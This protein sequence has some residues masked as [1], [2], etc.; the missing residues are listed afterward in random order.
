[1]EA[2]DFSLRE[3]GDVPLVAAAIHDGHGVRAEVAAA[4]ALTE[5]KRLREEDPFTGGWTMI[6]STRIVG[7]RSRFEVDLNRPRERA[8]Y[9]RPEDAWGLHVWKQ[10]PPAELIDRSLEL[11]DAFYHD[12][13]ALL[14]RAARRFGRF[15]VY[16]LHSYNHRRDGPEAP[17]ADPE[18]NPEVNIGT[19]SMDRGR[20]GPVVDAFMG[21][22]R[23]FDYGGRRLDVRENVK[24]RGGHFS[25][26]IH[27]RFPETACSLAIEFKKF[28]MDEWSG[29]P[30]PVQLDAIR[31]AL[32]S[33][34]PA[35]LEALA[36]GNGA[37]GDLPPAHRERV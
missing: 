30:D 22:L 36:G 7:L 13:H 24:F 17:A 33:T 10:E 28:F 15:V 25:Q 16:D 8:V 27:E 29:E 4:L 35:V 34:V 12:V 31:Q 5:F 1:V 2:H 3:G 37:R 21:S 6:A 20:W 19:G 14:S 9:R 26:W 18:A 32:A 23:A 11:Y